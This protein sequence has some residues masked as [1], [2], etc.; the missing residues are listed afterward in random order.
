MV[1]NEVNV[2]SFLRA[3]T[4][5]QYDSFEAMMVNW[6]P[7]A[8]EDDENIHEVNAVDLFTVLATGNETPVPESLAAL[9]SACNRTVCGPEWLKGA[10]E[11]VPRSLK[12]LIETRD[13]NERFR[14]GNGGV[15]TSTSRTRL[16]VVLDNKVFCLCRA[17]HVSRGCG[18]PL[19]IGVHF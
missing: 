8:D 15:L 7:D 10:L 2:V 16:P 6:E 13:E 12:H 18:I 5:F 19:F 17:Q 4:V 9:D 1:E 11:K 14:F 3:P